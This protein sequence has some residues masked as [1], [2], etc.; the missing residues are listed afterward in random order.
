VKA[1]ALGCLAITVVLHT[2]QPTLSIMEYDDLREGQ[3]E[4]AAAMALAV[5]GGVLLGRY[6]RQG[7]QRDLL[8]SAAFLVLA[9]QNV[10]IAV[11]T[12]VYDSLAASGFAT[13]TVAAWGAVGAVLLTAAAMVPDR[14]ARNV[15]RTGRALLAACALL[16]AGTAVMATLLDESLPRAFETLPTSVEEI[17]FMQQ[18]LLLFAYECLLALGWALAALRF[19]TIAHRDDDTLLRWLSLAAVLATAASVNYAVFPSQFTE[20]LYGGD[21]FLVIAVGLVLYGAIRVITGTEAALVRSALSTERRRVASELRAGVAQELALMA[22]QTR[23]LATQPAEPQRLDRLVE[24]VE[25]ALDESRGAISALARP[26][27]EPLAS[28][29]AHAAREVADP[30]GVRIEL[31]LEEG[32]AVSRDWRDLLVRLTRESVGIASRHGHANA[33]SLQ[34]RHGRHVTLRIVDDGRGYGDESDGSEHAI[35]V[36]GMRERTE[37]LG[38]SFSYEVCPTTGAA[39]EVRLP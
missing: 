18:H 38:A 30:A 2:T 8:T 3:L 13:W 19:V 1:L 37:M 21:L 39:V 16:L 14:S 36:R 24:S 28:A 22:T 17:G 15:A 5:A 4:A 31:D 25:R 10:L 32:T 12:P 27:D 23:L 34:L 33:V 26:V 35:A 29:L 6:W 9:A 11:A 20:L 7:S